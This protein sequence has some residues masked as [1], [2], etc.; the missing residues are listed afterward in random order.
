MKHSHFRFY[1]ELNDFLPY[2][3]RFSTLDRDFH[4]TPSVK[5]SIESFGV[6]PAE[7]DLVVA[8]GESVDLSYRLRDGDL[9]SVYPMF[10]SIDVGSTTKVRA[11]S[12]RETSFVVDEN[13]GTLARYLRLLGFEVVCEPGTSDGDLARISR[14]QRSVLLTRDIGLLKRNE[15]THGY[16]VRSTDPLSQTVE[17]VRRFDLVGALRPLE[18][19]SATS[20]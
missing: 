10:E 18:R 2:S 5:H 7:V 6:P 19:A 8:N 1:A 15:I 11:E 14:R 4:I 12:L 20:G 9:I 3:E 17:V 16:V 13:L